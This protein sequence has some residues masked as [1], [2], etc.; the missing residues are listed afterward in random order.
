MDLLFSYNFC[1]Y[2]EEEVLPKKSGYDMNP[3]TFNSQV[4]VFGRCYR[5]EL[6]ESYCNSGKLISSAQPR[7]QRVSVALSRLTQEAASVLDC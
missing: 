5:A 6:K 3:E 4:A 7:F 1:A 2:L